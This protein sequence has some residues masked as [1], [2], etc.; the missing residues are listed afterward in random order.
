MPR[1]IFSLFALVCVLFAAPAALAQKKVTAKIASLKITDQKTPLFNAAKEG[2]K[3]SKDH[4]GKIE[5]KFSTSSK[6]DWVDEIQ[7]R[8]LVLVYP[9]T[10]KTPIG[11]SINTTYV[12]INEGNHTVAVYIRPKFFERYFKSG[13]LVK[14]AVAA[15]AEI[16]YGGQR[17]DNAEQKCAQ[18]PKDW[19]K[20]ADQMKQVKGALLPRSKT[21][22]AV[23]DYDYYEDEKLDNEE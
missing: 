9:D 22:F 19:F 17:L 3:G 13:R 21:P 16:V 18:A 8:W 23:I 2:S 6:G 1:T 10:S 7:V 11:L 20:M 14:T 4:W 12:D 5:L 15:Y